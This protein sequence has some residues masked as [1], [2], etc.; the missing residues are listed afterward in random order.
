M[1]SRLERVA[2][3]R[4]FSITPSAKANLKVLAILGVDRVGD[5]IRLAATK[6]LDDMVVLVRQFRR[7]QPNLAMPI[8]V[9]VAYY[10][11][12]KAAFLIGT[13][14]DRIFAPF[15]PP[16]VVL[17]CALVLTAKP[18][19]WRYIAAAF[20]A[21]AIAEIE[22]GM[23]ASQLLVAFATNCLV[24]VFSAAGM[25][26]LVVGPR[27]FDSL[28][29]ACLYILITALAAPMIV[30]LFGAFVPILGGGELARYPMFWLD[31][32]LANAL[33]SLTLG[34]VALIWAAGRG[35]LSDIV[36]GWAAVEAAILGVSL[37]VVCSIV[38]KVGADSVPI[39]FLPALFYLP[40][41]LALWAALRFGVKGA[42][43]AVLIV[44]TVLIWHTLKGPNLFVS[45][46]AA[47][48]VITMQVFLLGLSVPMLMLGA[49]IDEA[50]K[51][52][53]TVRDSEERMMAAAVS[54]DVCLWHFDRSSDDQLWLTEHGRQMLGLPNAEPITR[55]ILINAVHPDDRESARQSLR[56]AFAAGKLADVEFRIV[57][58]D[59]RARWI[60][61][62]AR[63]DERHDPQEIS[64]S[65]TDVTERK[66]A[67]IELA[68]QR[69]EIAHLM[70]VS[71]L[72]EL[73]GG[74]AHEITQPL[75]A[76]LSN[77]EAARILL[78]QEK[79]NIDE[80]GEALD[81]IIY[82]GNRAGEV[83]HRLR[84]LLKKSE[85]KFEPVDINDLVN[86]TVQLLH[87]ELIAR[88]VKVATSLAA[89][90]PLVS[91]DSVQLQQVLLNLALNAIDAM[92]DV[93]PSRRMIVITTK[94]TDES[95]LNV[96]IADHGIGLKTFGSED[97]FKPFVT[98]KT[99]GL[100][101]G[102]SLCSAIAKL[103][104][105]TLTLANNVDGGATA[106]L[107]LPLGGALPVMNS[108][109][110]S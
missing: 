75:S 4:K 93:V 23:G 12:A 38:F 15:W 59:G 90:L 34:P 13:L 8:F 89:E 78:R 101:L 1:N 108:R 66:A 7:L 20:P 102:L 62:R 16:N 103:H 56:D 25:Q 2:S 104:E 18:Q 5:S 71:M 94:V 55:Q 82:E 29:K 22:V 60:R 46:D 99:H 100:G 98:T 51:A 11:G 21:H 37:V 43:C 68:Q 44:T 87:H 48:S 54:A 109:S 17:F 91:G 92:N 76:I 72:G 9:A 86:S 53:R 36:S 24:A 95:T 58:S 28:R 30:S 80:I 19:W 45:A 110:G 57:Q 26:G 3:A 69:H 77:A 85:A 31:W 42:S 107:T 10:I 41:P 64:G 97:L 106:T 70:R 52:T 83:I 40:L 32:Y 105:G 63:A 49:A 84:G 79:L 35:R 14:S 6:S 88:Q 74:I 27:W 67:D 33:G 96:A 50:R 81:D 61:C 39:S 47:L 65:F 73:S